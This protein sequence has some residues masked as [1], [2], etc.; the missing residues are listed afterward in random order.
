MSTDDLETESLGERIRY[1]RAAR[2]WSQAHL[3]RQAGMKKA[4]LSRYEVGT[5]TP[6]PEVLARIAFALGVATEW[7]NGDDV[8]INAHEHKDGFKEVPIPRESIA[9]LLQYAELTGV[10]ISTAIKKAIEHAL[11]DIKADD[12]ESGG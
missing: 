3:A 8:A 7:L 6:R 10:D 9:Q 4:Q 2:G 1:V 5:S 11:K 12:G